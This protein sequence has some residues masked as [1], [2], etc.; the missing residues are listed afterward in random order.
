MPLDRDIDFG[1]DLL[2]GSQPIS[3]PPY[4]MAPPELKEQLQELID[5][6]FI[7]PRGSQ[8]AVLHSSGCHE[9][10][11]GFEEALRVEENEEGHSGVCG[12]VPKFPEGEA[13]L[14]AK[15]K[16]H[17]FR[18]GSVEESAGRGGDLGDRAYYAQPLT[19]SFHHFSIEFKEDDWVFL[20]VSPV[21]D[22]IQFRKVRKVSPRYIGPYKVLERIGQ[23]AY[24]LE[25][26]QELSSMHL[27]FH[28]S[29]LKKV[30]HNPSLIIPL[31]SIELNESLTHEEVS[32]V[33]LDRQ[34]CKLRNKEIASVKVL[35]RNQEVEKAT[36]EA[37]EDIKKKYPH[38]FVEPVGHI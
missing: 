27:V 4:R 8:L 37:E 12:S 3:I 38:L 18:E 7:R 19:S 36:W 34:V 32:V 16:E 29:I 14:K 31:E 10:V 13:G 6:G 22:V 2:P 9:D 35:W 25:L 1:I 30:I 33:I 11:S 21:I 5:K 23:V 17:C 28:V 20:K 15:V 26:P 24:R